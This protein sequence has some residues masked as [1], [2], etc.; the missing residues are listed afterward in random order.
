MRHDYVSEEE[1]VTHNMVFTPTSL[2]Q[3]LLDVGFPV[4]A[5]S[6]LNVSAI[7]FMR[8]PT[9][10]QCDLFGIEYEK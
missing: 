7:A 3:I 5:V 9:E 8:Q 10:A 6:P 2:R 1:L 4:V